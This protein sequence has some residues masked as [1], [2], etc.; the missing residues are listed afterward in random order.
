[1]GLDDLSAWML[2]ELEPVAA[3]GADLPF[4][5]AWPPPLQLQ[6]PLVEEAAAAVKQE[7][8][9]D[10]ESILGPH[11][12]VLSASMRA[13]ANSGDLLAQSMAFPASWLHSEAEGVTVRCQGPCCAR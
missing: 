9:F 13:R 2:P 3:A 8:A 7:A 12:G 11:T 5:A 4:Q 1:M 10:F 6:L